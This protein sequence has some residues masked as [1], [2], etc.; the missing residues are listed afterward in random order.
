LRKKRLEVCGN[1]TYRHRVDFCRQHP[2]KQVPAIHKV[3]E[4]DLRGAELDHL[5]DIR[6][7]FAP[8]LLLAEKRFGDVRTLRYEE[9]MTIVFALST[10]RAREPPLRGDPFVD[11]HRILGSRLD[12]FRAGV[13]A[14]D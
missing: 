2:I 10:R 7:L 4:L 14:E 5:L 9:A 1:L 11:R 6:L 13:G 8:E 12:A 3:L